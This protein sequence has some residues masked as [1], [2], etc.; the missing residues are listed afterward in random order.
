MATATTARID[1]PSRRWV[2]CARGP[3]DAPPRVASQPP[4]DPGVAGRCPRASRRSVL[5]D[6]TED[7][8]LAPMRSMRS[9]GLAGLGAASLLSLLAACGDPSEPFVIVLGGTDAGEDGGEIVDASSDATVPSDGSVQDASNDAAADATVQDTGVDAG[10]DAGTDAGAVDAGPSIPDGN[11]VVTIGDAQVTI[12]ALDPALLGDGGIRVSDGGL[13]GADGG[14]L[15]PREF[16]DLVNG[17]TCQRAQ[18][19]CCPGCSASDLATPGVGFSQSKC[20]T[21]LSSSGLL[22]VLF[23]NES[24]P[25][26]NLVANPTAMA[27]CLAVV[28]QA[29]L[30]C[31][32]ISAD[33]VRIMRTVC[34]DSYNS[35]LV[36]GSVC[37]SSFQCQMPARC[38]GA[39]T[40]AGADAGKTCQALVSAGGNCVSSTECTPRGMQGTPPLFCNLAAPPAQCTG[41]RAAG[42]TCASEGDCGFGTCPAA[43][44]DGGVRRCSS[45][46]PFASQ[47]PNDNASFCKLYT[48]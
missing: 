24:I 47:D 30:S 21:G 20:T 7:D 16:R 42:E 37:T 41:F 44:V 14:T 38:A 19:C 45:T 4:P 46:L 32:S 17:I 18:E 1:G 8:M 10:T 36:L 15:T 26:G 22:R 43:A 13:A 2:P 34:L 11:T 23:G 39:V 3:H 12:P 25:A 5:D 48:P 6:R 35:N 27:R 33:N 31:Q 9:W 28:N 29:V 40:D